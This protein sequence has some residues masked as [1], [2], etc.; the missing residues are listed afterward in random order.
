MRFWSI[1]LTAISGEAWGSEGDKR[2]LRHAALGLGALGVVLAAGPAWPASYYTQRL[3]DPKAVYLTK[4]SFAVQGDGVADDTAALQHAIDRVQETTRQGIVFVPEGRYRLTNTV[5]VWPGIRLIGYGMKRPVL[6]LAKNT[7][8]YEDKNKEH[9]MLFFAGRRPAN[10]PGTTAPIDEQ[11]QDANPGTFYS[12]ISNIDIEIQDGN[13]GASAIRSKYAQ[14]CFLAHMDIQIGSGIAGIHEAGNVVEDVRFLG[15]QYGVWTSKPS[16][17]WQFTMVDAVF[18]GQREAAI[19]EREAGLTLIRPIFRDVPTVISIDEGFPDELW[20]KDA[21]MENIAGP[22]VVVS[23]EKNARTEINMEGVLCRGVPQFAAF[24]E[25]GKKLAGPGDPYQVKLFSHGLHYSDI[26]AAGEYKTLFEAAPLSALPVQVASDLPDLPARDTWVDVRALGAKGDGQTDDTEVLHRAIV[27]HRTL[28]FPSGTYV[29]SDT[30]VLRPDTVLIGLHPG[31]TQIAL[32]D[33]TA[34]YQGIGG[35]KAMVEAP[36]GGTNIV[37]GLGLYTNGIN[38][39]AVAIKWMAGKNSLMNDVRLLGGHGTPTLNGG[40]ENPYNSNHSADPE[41]R[42]RWDAQYPSLWVTDGG[43]GTFFDIW[44]P[45]S[46]AQAG[47]LVSDTTTEGRIYEMSSEHHVRHEVQLRNAAN[48]KIYALQTEGERGESGEDL[49]LEIQSSRNITVANLHIYRVISMYQPFPWAV[50][51]TDSTGIHFRNFHSY[52]NSKV[53]YDS[54]YDQTHNIELRQREFAWLDLSKQAPRPRPHVGSPILAP[55]AKVEKL[56]GGF[57]NISGGA[58]SPSGDLYFVDAHWQRIHRWDSSARQLT[59]VRDNALDPVQLAF[60][61]AGNLLVV[62]YAGNGTVYSFKPDAPGLDITLLQRE[63]SIPRP[64]LLPVLPVGDWRL[65]G[66]PQPRPFQYVS[67]DGSTF[68]AADELF[69]NGTTFWGVKG[70]PMLRA[71]GL[72]PA[73]PS[74]PF[75]LTSEAEMRTYRATV[76]TDGSLSDMKLFVEQGGEGVAVDAQGNVYIAAGQIYVYNPSGR[77]IGTIEVP[78]RPVQ[79]LFGGPDRSTLFI[80]AR[81][82][83]YAVRTLSPGR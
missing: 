69:T 54:L 80:A 13:P 33:G 68:L 32:L 46:F 57:Y 39:R 15:G 79:L 58:I 17:G 64:G 10:K 59:T 67:P 35:P 7:A 70:S 56:A 24:R 1:T 25:S 63:P 38:P 60:D 28:Y 8:G 31:T 23:A 50:K 66:D 78:E 19:R 75:Y 9:F 36:K 4:E 26:G 73:K 21:R 44:T 30:L 5:Y 51:V 29:V 65:E 83:L 37:L 45:S 22:A 20:V 48:W 34:A 11:V 55:A 16:P 74:Q 12:A 6:V 77:L 76:G 49:P 42:R 40:R 14:H 18:Q 61:R 62:S 47:M 27:E 71:F 43:G 81:S 41:P 82:S 3:N 72:A 53:S 2:V 52:S